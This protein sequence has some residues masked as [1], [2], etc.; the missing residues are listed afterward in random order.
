MRLVFWRLFQCWAAIKDPIRWID[1]ALLLM[2]MAVTNGI[3]VLMAGWL[4][5]IAIESIPFRASVVALVGA[6]QM[7]RILRLD[8]RDGA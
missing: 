6:V 7:S 8:G 4:H 5:S 1:A 2:A 3:L